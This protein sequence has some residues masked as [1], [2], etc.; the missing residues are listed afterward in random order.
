M[1]DGRI[2]FRYINTQEQI[3]DISTKAL[4]VDKHDYFVK[5]LQSEDGE[6]ELELD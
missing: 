1:L 5:K 6:H 3:A 4:G 2:D